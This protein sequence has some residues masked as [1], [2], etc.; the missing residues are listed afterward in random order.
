MEAIVS[1]RPL[2]RDVTSDRVFAAAKALINDC[3]HFDDSHSHCRYSRE[4][5]LPSRV[6]DVGQPGDSQPHIKLRINDTEVYEPYVALSY[7]WGQR[8]NPL[9]PGQSISLEKGKLQDLIKE[10][11]LEELSK[12]IQDAVRVCREL[13][14]RYL[15]VD[16]LCIIQDCT[17]DKEKE[18][19]QMAA[20]YK[21]ATVTIVAATSSNAADGFL[22]DAIR[23]YLPD[24]KFSIPMSNEQ[25]GEVYL[26][27]GCYE[28][29]HTIDERGWALQEFMLS[30]RM[31]IFSEYELLWQCQQV[32]LQSVTGLGLDYLQ[33]LD[34]LPWMAFGDDEAASY[35]SVEADKLYLWTSVVEQYTRRKLTDPEDRLPAITG[36]ISELEVVWGDMNIYGLW[37]KWF[38]GLL[39]WYKPRSQRAEKRFLRR[40]PSWS[41]ASLDGEISHE[42]PLTSED[43]RVRLITQSA[44]ELIG[45]KLRDEKICDSKLETIEELPDLENACPDARSKEAEYVLLGTVK[46]SEKNSET[47]VG[48]LVEDVGH[49]VY[50]RL[51]L[52]RFSDMSI[53]KDIEPKVIRLEPKL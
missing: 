38:I 41:W 40:A 46:E 44:A 1:R 36:V 3:M 24:R 47:G 22:T 43:A 18:I 29:K 28:P 12:S 6:L 21:N 32:Q 35:G 23:P 17:I 33:Y 9:L 10:I 26:S 49:R 11:R 50:R 45:R 8:P 25:A 2:R 42:G 19:S 31:L 16:V 37:K 48:L 39:V 51:G 27:T 15:W 30:P 20:I 13:G 7:C 5:V 4:K 14:F 52:A 53:W 34:S